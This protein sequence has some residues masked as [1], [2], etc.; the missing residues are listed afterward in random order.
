MAKTDAQII[1]DHSQ[2]C[3]HRASLELRIVHKVI[4]DA[5]ETG[6]KLEIN[7]YEKDEYEQYKDWGIVG[8]LFNLDDAHLLFS[9][10]GK[11][12]GWVRFVFGNDGYDV[13][14]DYTI[15]LE[16]FLK[17]ANALAN[18]LEAAQ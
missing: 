10:D 12:C 5:K 2:G 8:M 6:Y 18:E 11:S 17:G 9:K 15:N 14:S 4:N 3:R 13:I 7:E 16:D 1:A